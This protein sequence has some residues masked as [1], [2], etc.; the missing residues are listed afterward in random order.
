MQ[1]D[2]CAELLARLKSEGIS[3]AV[4]TCGFVSRA[5]LDKVIPF[6]DVFLYDMKAMLAG[7][8]ARDTVISAE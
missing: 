8:E 1:A 2:F 6:T 5:A 3:T 7:E 4:D